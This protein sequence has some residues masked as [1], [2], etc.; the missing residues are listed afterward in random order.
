MRYAII[1]F[2]VHGAKLSRKLGELLEDAKGYHLSKY[3]EEGLEKVEGSLKEW[4]KMNFKDYEV[5]IYIGAT[6]IAVRAIAPFLVSKDKDPA[7]LCIDEL[8]QNVIPLVSGHIGGANGCAKYIASL[9]GG[10]AIIS[11]ATDLEGRFAVDEW[12]VE[13]GLILTD[14]K[15]AKSI[16]SDILK[17]KTIGFVSDFPVEGKLPKQVLESSYGEIGIYIGYDKGKKPFKETL[18]LIPKGLTLGIGCR[19]GT[20]FEQIERLIRGQLEKLDIPI[21]AIGKVVSIDLK[22]EEQGL[23]E[24]ATHYH[25][26]ISFY[27]AHELNQIEGDFTPS[28]FVKQ[29]TG[30][31]NVCERS[32]VKGSDG[33]KLLLKKVALDGVTMAL[34][35]PYYTVTFEREGLR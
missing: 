4:T 5:L 18:W 3:K 20:S 22:Q 14:L 35:M 24:W 28:S 10:R 31:E 15:K 32:A 7:V 12:A 16:A 27:S 21:E 17:D 8:G 34:A 29:I 6:G 9:I 33:G 2:T 13:R 25:K 30:V 23:L 26:S 11:T 1:S 19:K